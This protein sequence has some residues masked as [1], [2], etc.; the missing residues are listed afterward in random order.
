MKNLFS[1]TI[2]RK[3]LFAALATFGL[4]AAAPAWAAPVCSGTTQTVASGG[5]V[6][7]AFLLT[8]GNCVAAGDKI[9][10]NFAVGGSVSGAGGANF[11]FGGPTGTVTIG[12]QGALGP[13]TSGTLDYSVAVDPALAQG[14]QIVGLEK[15]FTL[16][17]IGAGLA[18]ANLQGITT[19]A[20]NPPININCTRTVNPN[21]ST[22]P[23]T[24]FFAAVSSLNIH[25]TI[26]TLANANVTALTDTIIQA[27]PSVPEPASL[28]L[29]GVGL[30]GLG[31]VAR[32]KR[33]V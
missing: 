26:T 16:N 23:E 21:A 19:P 24:N 7:G 29:L 22:C 8:A 20:T 13:N 1:A 9:F 17:A 30:I 2:V 31:F 3:A 32:R 27:P 15:D 11:L 33:S 4:A 25:E 12:F 5:S 28:G 14:F 10:G 18:S 6:T